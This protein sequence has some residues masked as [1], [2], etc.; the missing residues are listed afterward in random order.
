MVTWTPLRSERPPCMYEHGKNT[1]NHAVLVYIITTVTIT[2][3]G[4][5][6]L[7]SWFWF[8]LTTLTVTEAGTHSGHCRPTALYVKHRWW[9]TLYT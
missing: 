2:P 5:E 8:G 1:Q 9:I 7:L 6:T 4:N 3:G